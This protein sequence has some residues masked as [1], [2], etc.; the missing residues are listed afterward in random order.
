M[1][2][3]RVTMNEATLPPSPN[4]YLA[5]ILAC[6]KD[7]TVAWGARNSIVVVTFQGDKKIYKYSIISD[8][9]IDRVTSLAFSPKFGEANHNLLVSGGDENVVRIWNMDSMNAV[10]AHSFIDTQQKVIGVDWSR[11]NTNIVCCL[12]TDGFLVI[13]NVAHNVTQQ[14]C[15]GKVTATCLS[16][17]PHDPDLV[18]AGTKSGLVY[19]INVHGNGKIVYKLRGH[20]TEIS[21]L[22]WCPVDSNVISGTQAK[23]SLL[24]SGS[25]DRSIYVWR[26][27][28]DGRYQI[29]L[30]LPNTPLDSHQHRSKLGAATG[31]WTA[32]CW[33]APKLLL[34]S[35]SW[36]ELI[37]WDLSINSKP[38]QGC[39]LIHAY[40]ARG[41]FCIANVQGGMEANDTN[42]RLAD[43]SSIMVWTIAQDRHV[44]CCQ[45]T[46]ANSKITYNVPTQGG[47]TYC[48]A[49][50]PLDTSRVAFGVGDA[51]L[52]V[53]N[54]C[55]PHE[56]SFDI[57]MLW[58][59]IKG[60]VMAISWHPQKENLLAFGTGEGR[61][62]VF[63]TNTSKP[64]ILYR[65]YHRH[66]VYTLG[67][68][69]EPNG[70][71]TYV[72]YSCG[73]GEL[74]YYNPEKPNQ[75]PTSVIKKD[76]TE[77][78]WKPDYSCLAIGLENGSVSFLNRNLKEC[79]PAI[80]SLK[81]SIQCLE[82]HP[83]STATDFDLS[84]L[85][86]QL[87][88][89]TIANSIVV[90]D[91]SDLA[92]NCTDTAGAS[93]TIKGS[94]LP[95]IVCTLMGHTAKIFDLAWS[96]HI[97]GYLASA[98]CDNTV[99]V[100]KTESQELMGTYTG[101][102]G[103]VYCCMWSPLDPDLII[104]GSADFTVRIWKVSEQ[105]VR[106][107]AENLLKPKKIRTKKNKH[108]TER[109][110][111]DQ[112]S[113]LNEVSINGLDDDV[114]DVTTVENATTEQEIKE[115]LAMDQIKRKK[116]KKSTYFPTMAKAASNKASLLRS[117]TEHFER[118]LSSRLSSV[119]KGL[120]QIAD[121]VCDADDTKDSIR[122]SQISSIFG[123]K[124]DVIKL[125]DME[126]SVHAKLSQHDT[127]VEMDLW[128][129]N[130]KQNLQEATKEKRLNDFLVSLAPS[131]SYKEW[132]V[133]C[134]N[135]A[136]Q[137]EFEGNRRKAVSYL[138]CIHKIERAI[139]V[140]VE[141]KMFK[142][143]YV[144]AK[145]KLDTSDPLVD[146]LLE[147]WAVG[148][149][150][151]GNFEEAV[152]CYIKLGNYGEAARLLSRRKDMGSLEVAARLALKSGDEEFS[153]TIIEQA[154]NEALLRAD[155]ES[156]ANLI[157]TFPQILHYQVTVAA[158]KE[159]NGILESCNDGRIWDWL[160]GNAEHSM[161]R[162]LSHCY[163][164]CDHYYT[165][166]LRSFETVGVS[167]N[168]QALWVEVGSQIA[169]A[170]TCVDNEK[171]LRHLV[172]AADAA[173]RY[174]ASIQSATAVV[175]RHKNFLIKLLSQLEEK[176][177]MSE[178]CLFAA[179]EPS[180][181]KSLRAYLCYG[182][183]NW[184]IDSD[185]TYLEKEGRQELVISL[186]ENVIRDALA[187]Q[188]VRHNMMSAEINKLEGK[189]T[190]SMGKSQK[191]GNTSGDAQE[192]VESLMKRLALIRSNREKYLSERLCAPNPVLVYSKARELVSV[193]FQGETEEKMT[194]ILMETWTEATS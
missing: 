125:L 25:K 133:T 154:V 87:A 182:I 32:V 11:A 64:P 111:T 135:Y 169:L 3:E 59:K 178:D 114:S 98:S 13:W 36:G 88:V 104:T 65:Q 142:E 136:E 170:I 165:K 92:T 80:H 48:I 70:K 12:S 15:L 75:E 184:V 30:T 43:T 147:T 138:L 78:S 90:L 173:S 153:A 140:F 151:E 1:I 183:L 57:T 158:L 115:S 141:G 109:M 67:W 132:Q 113:N 145:T 71:S 77:F 46:A 99:Q 72:L 123:S 189:L 91:L 124:E 4:W 20:D 19:V 129:D 62:G 37:S 181:R 53:W 120:S 81:K 159:L 128:C 10:M 134:E 161:L 131:L 14:I 143:A 188:T 152:Q 82:W 33:A 179:K 55:E 100:W 172:A 2:S 28:G 18:A 76:C 84:P 194:R 164:N 177:P 103:P 79:G 171:K 60:K 117:I 160:E 176:S 166:L 118:P 122:E 7:G 38:R 61:V 69:P 89:S 83:E 175:G 73:D 24:A 144:L 54:L 148:T 16:C 139:Q 137:L 6:A 126:K 149:A 187:K 180:I 106:P 45:V 193:L 174:E 9:H 85:R 102:C 49:A 22:S 56:N 156:I 26:A 68:G 44:V 119:G 108:K 93:T 47:Y 58:Q 42:W 163:P 150:K 63:D 191:I 40:H 105:E 130:L 52:R 185:I 27:G 17:C 127:V 29:V 192:D 39:K 190:I 110:G 168:T 157:K 41:L 162:N 186:I 167:K 107:V 121:N 112:A 86:H 23:D 8:A 155:Y 94:L 97:S 51:M 96:P 34:S 35:S 101:H 66:T 5:N 50:S 21:S 116:S 95:K 146:S 74:I 31:G